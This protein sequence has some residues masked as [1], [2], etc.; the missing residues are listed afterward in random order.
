MLEKD[1]EK[2]FCN[3]V[4]YLG[5]TAEKYSSPG[6]RAVPD[7]LITLPGGRIIFAEIKAPGKRPTKSQLRDHDRRRAMGCAVVVIDTW[8]KALTF[9]GDEIC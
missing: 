4:K 5:G 6:R 3:R 2:A 8:Q 1:I 9:T 7:R